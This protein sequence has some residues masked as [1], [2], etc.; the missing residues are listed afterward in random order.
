MPKIQVYIYLVYLNQA[1]DN[2]PIYIKWLFLL[3]FILSAWVESPL[4]FVYHLPGI[5][6]ELP[7]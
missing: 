2:I 6:S 1:S 4:I 3:L 5:Q 7:N